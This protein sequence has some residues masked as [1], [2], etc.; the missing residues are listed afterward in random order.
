M[1]SSSCRTLPKDDRPEMR[2]DGIPEEE[3]ERFS[4]LMGDGSHPISEYV[5]RDLLHEAG[6]QEVTRYFG[7]FLVEG[8]FAIKAWLSLL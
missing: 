2:S 5:L 1:E 4:Q 8:W 7:A 3:W 6:F